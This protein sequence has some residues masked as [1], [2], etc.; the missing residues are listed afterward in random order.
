MAERQDKEVRELRLEGAGLFLIVA[1]LGAGLVGAFFVGRWFERSSAP[2]AGLE[3]LA[4]DPLEN[5]VPPSEVENV[6]VTANRFDTIEDGTE[7][8][9]DRQATP[10]PKDPDPVTQPPAREPEPAPATPPATATGGPFYVQI[11]AYRDRSSAD[12]V[13]SELGSAG[14]PAKVFS[15]DGPSGQLYKVRV[16][17]Y[18]ARDDADRIAGELKTKGHPGAYPTRV[19]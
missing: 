17:G 18:A 1:V 6:D 15:E 8:E 10:P 12:K 5:V 2:P 3:Q 7:A 9:P 13:V 4:S 11:G 16:G 19:E 14:Y